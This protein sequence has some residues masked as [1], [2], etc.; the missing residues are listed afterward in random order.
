MESG[1]L[2]KVSGIIATKKVLILLVIGFI[3]IALIFLSDFIHP[4]TGNTQQTQQPQ[5]TQNS[6]VNSFESETENRL[7][8]IIGKIDGVGRVEVLVTVESGVENVYEQDNK[9]TTD[10][11]QQ[12]SGDGNIQTQDNNDN[13]QNPIVV[14]NSDGGQQAIVKEQLQPQI[15][16]VVVVCDGGGNADVQESVVDTVST[17]LGLPTNQISVSRMQPS[18][19]QVH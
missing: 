19:Q 8:S 13:E 15:L 11:S 6:S 12:N 1:L 9:T 10:K 3:G 18:S 16:G 2:K 4:G 5:Q 14:N 17:A 7:E